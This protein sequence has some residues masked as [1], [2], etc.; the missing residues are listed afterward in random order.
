MWIAN[1]VCE[2]DLKIDKNFNIINSIDNI[3]SE[4]PTLIVGIN[5]A[6]N[7]TDKISYLNRKINE[8]TFWTFTKVEKRDLF[9]EDLFH[10]I[11]FSYNN[12]LKQIKF[13]FIDLILS[14]TEKINLT[15]KN[16]SSSEKVI[17]FHHLNIVYVYIKNTIYG[18][19]LRQVEYIG[20]SIDKFMDKIK[21][22]S[23]ILLQDDKI[24]IEYNKELSIFN[25][26]IKY[27]PFI[28]SIRNDE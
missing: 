18:F 6:K 13:E 21:E 22:I 5:N 19:D 17:T 14:D 3:I 23:T 1:I 26:E 9:E 24:L 8:N 7:Y 16:I 12:L 20:K 11:E 25:N 27:V 28:H 15:F 10:F 2:K 4:L